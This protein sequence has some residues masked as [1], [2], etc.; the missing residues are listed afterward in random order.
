MVV[1][2]RWYG[3]SC[4]LQLISRNHVFLFDPDV[5]HQK[6]GAAAGATTG[7]TLKHRM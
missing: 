5:L 7:F 2:Q 4:L 1:V 3:D 6:A